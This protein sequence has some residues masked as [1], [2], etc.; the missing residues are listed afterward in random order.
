MCN[1]RWNRRSYN[2]G[3]RIS[4][5]QEP[6]P[7]MEKGMEGR[8][9][10]P[11]VLRFWLH[12]NV[13]CFWDL[14]QA[15]Q[16]RIPMEPGS[17][18]RLLVDQRCD[19]GVASPIVGRLA[20]RFGVRRVILISVI[21]VALICG[22]QSLLTRHL[23]PRSFVGR[24]HRGHHDAHLRE[25]HFELVRPKPRLGALNVILRRRT[26]RSRHASVRAVT[27]CPLWMA[28]SVLAFF[29]GRVFDVYHSYVLMTN[30]IAAASIVAAAL[31]YLLP[32]TSGIPVTK[33][34]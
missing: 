5:H 4:R 34:L 6:T 8:C 23:C 14:S 28:R 33:N 22:P 30:I 32:K 25:G 2:N 31:F 7:R 19:F 3:G 13:L 1:G 16:L 26:G 24:G 9:C 11:T 17:N 21:L 12:G 10:L 29:M 18:F 20:D 27:H 15:A